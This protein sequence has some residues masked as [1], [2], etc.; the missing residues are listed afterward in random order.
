MF[1]QSISLAIPP[2]SGIDFVG[3][4]KALEEA[5]AI[6]LVE[7]GKDWGGD[8]K[9]DEYELK[10]GQ[11]DAK[12]NVRLFYRSGRNGSNPEIFEI[13]RILI[14]TPNFQIS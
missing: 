6:R 1:V 13:R 3:P 12:F 14:E 5:G 10:N 4:I 2:N 9:Y 8:W 7:K 11:S